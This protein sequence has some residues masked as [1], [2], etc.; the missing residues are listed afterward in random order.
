MAADFGAPGV[1]KT[2]Y[3]PATN[4]RGE[5]IKATCK[6]GSVTIPYP[7]ELGGLGN[8]NACHWEAARKLLELRGLDWGNT[9]A[10]GGHESGCYFTPIRGDNT[11][12]L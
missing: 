10:A 8:V 4:Y 9:W 2:T 12:T 11:I 1:I 7:Y 3:L 6:A 5:R